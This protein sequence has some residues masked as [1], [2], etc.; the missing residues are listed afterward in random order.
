MV[1]DQTVAAVFV[2]ALREL[3]VKYVFG[4]PSGGWVDYMEALRL[5]D[6]IEFILTTH[7]GAAGM[8]AEVSLF[9]SQGMQPTP[10]FIAA[11]SVVS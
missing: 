10:F 1:K 7:E 6:G 3:G 5:A 8:M 2:E 11:T 9:G 4:V